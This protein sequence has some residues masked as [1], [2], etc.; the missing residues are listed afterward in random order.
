MPCRATQVGQVI[1]ETSDKTLS[2]GR[3]NDKPSE[4]FCHETPM[5]SKN[6]KRYD[7]GRLEGVGRL[8]GIQYVGGGSKRRLLIAAGKSEAPG[9]KQKGCS[10]VEV[11]GGKSK[12]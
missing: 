3:G 8:K 6:G 10:V 11:S 7:I 9:P 5:N 4:Y 2:T 1:V 12:V